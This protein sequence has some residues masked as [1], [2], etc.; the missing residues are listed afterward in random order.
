[1]LVTCCAEPK[2]P[3]A[4]N[5]NPDVFNSFT[6]L[7]PSTSIALFAVSVPFEWSS[8]SVKYTPPITSCAPAIPLPSS[9]PVP[10]YNL[11]PPDTVACGA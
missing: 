7:L 2:E 4:A 9:A 1:M 10:I 11:S 8:I 3:D 6:C 5:F